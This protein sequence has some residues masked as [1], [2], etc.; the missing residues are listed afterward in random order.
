MLQMWVFWVGKANVPPTDGLIISH[1][2]LCAGVLPIEMAETVKE[3][4][5]ISKSA[6]R[7]YLDSRVV[8]VYISAEAIRFHVYM[9][10]RVSRI[11][12]FWGPEQW[13]YKS[14][15]SIPADIATWGFKISSLPHSV[16]LRGPAFLVNEVVNV[17]EWVFP[18]SWG[19]WRRRYQKEVVNINTET[20]DP[21]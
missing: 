2:E 3:E 21:S 1:L 20:S 4:L 17:N 11:R 5:D 12:L 7:I 14:S 9:C 16:W 18:C 10:N 13:G 6:L 15:E 19:G 8:L